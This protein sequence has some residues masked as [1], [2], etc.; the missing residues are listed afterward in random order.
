MIRSFTLGPVLLICAALFAL[1][2]PVLAGPPSAITPSVQPP[3]KHCESLPAV[4]KS[5][6]WTPPVP[7]VFELPNGMRIWH[8]KQT[9]TPLVSVQ[10]VFPGGAA[11][12]PEGKDGL[13][14]LMADLMDEGAGSRDA[15]QLDDAFLLLATDYAAK[16]STDGVVFSLDMLAENFEPSLELLAD[17]ILRPHFKAADFSRRRDQNVATALA[18]EAQPGMARTVVMRRALFGTGYGGAPATGTREGLSK[19]TADD[20]AEHYEATITPDGAVLVVVGDINEF[21]LSRAVEGAF[22]RWHGTPT[23]KPKAVAEAAPERGIYFIDF[24][25]ASQASVAVARRAA[26]VSAPDLFP[27]IVFNRALGGAFTSRLNL[28]LREDKGWTYGARSAFY[29]WKQAGL[30]VLMAQVKTDA[31]VGS[32]QEMFAEL[33]AAAG[34]RPITKAERDE[35]VHGQLAGLPTQFDRIS[36]TASKFS[37]LG[38]EGRRADYFDDWA[39]TLRS[40]TAGSAS[41]AAKRWGDLGQFVVVVAADPSLL[42]ELEALGLPIHRRDAQGR[43]VS[44]AGKEAP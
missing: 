13:T 29:R 10:L 5:T 44:A 42:P 19:L 39:A 38:L 8:I 22:G 12:D 18:R 17:I 33:E 32:I 31:T 21:W 35:A 11:T 27:A 23:I 2:T 36:T 16:V 9:Q 6:D 30:F 41:A 24:P 20:V 43:P 14:M 37:A 15:L 7:V 25:G 34:A 28:N 40:V 1:A 4:G 3:T 26:G